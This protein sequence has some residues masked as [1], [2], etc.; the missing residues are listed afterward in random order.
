[1]FH[2]WNSG[3]MQFFFRIASSRRFIRHWYKHCQSLRLILNYS[4]NSTLTNTMQFKIFLWIMLNVCFHTNFKHI[5]RVY[6]FS[7]VIAIVV[8]K[9][10]HSGR[11]IHIYNTA[12]WDQY[13]FL[14]VTLL[15]LWWDP[16][17]NFLP[18]CFKAGVYRGLPSLQFHQILAY[19]V[20]KLK[21][22]FNTVANQSF[23]FCGMPWRRCRRQAVCRWCKRF[24]PHSRPLF[25]E[26]SSRG[27]SISRNII[28]QDSCLLRSIQFLLLFQDIS[29]SPYKFVIFNFMNVTPG[30][31]YVRWNVTD[32]SLAAFD[33]YVEITWLYGNDP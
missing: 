27:I 3:R 11:I 33:N 18:L 8:L 24:R 2:W 31:S 26:R 1:M 29:S 9:F 32:S 16:V 25:P 4:R 14:Y 13:S 30:W 19:A 7:F 15:V 28:N 17:V 23:L 22:P 5:Y 20:P 21:P 12:D 10:L 6:W